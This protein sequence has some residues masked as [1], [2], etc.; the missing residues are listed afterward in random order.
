MAS[1]AGF[2]KDFELKD[3]LHMS[4][5]WSENTETAEFP[6]ILLRNGKFLKHGRHRVTRFLAGWLRVP[7]VCVL[8]ESQRVTHGS[9]IITCDLPFVI[10]QDHCCSIPWVRAVAKGHPES[11][12]GN[13]DFT[14]WWES[15]NF[16]YKKTVQGEIYID[17]AIFEKYNPPKKMEWFAYKEMKN[18]YGGTLGHLCFGFLLFQRHSC[19][20][21]TPYP[22]F[23]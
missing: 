23:T 16:T 13:V 1:I 11:S 7:K 8:K 21:A 17:M 9:L 6:C 19:I 20:P 22:G 15:L 2:L 4:G 5:T 10:M 12:R 18:G 3:L 14:F